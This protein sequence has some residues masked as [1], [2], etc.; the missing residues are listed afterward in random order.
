M[1]HRIFNVL[2]V[3]GEGR[4]EGKRKNRKLGSPAVFLFVFLFCFFGLL[5]RSGDGVWCTSSPSDRHSRYSVEI[6]NIK[7]TGWMR[8]VYLWDKI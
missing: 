5:W 1:D 7:P 3:D 4:R 2:M 6:V 8:H